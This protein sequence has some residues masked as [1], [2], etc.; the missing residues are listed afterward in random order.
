M[1]FIKTKKRNNALLLTI[2]FPVVKVPELRHVSLYNIDITCNVRAK[3]T[4]T[5][6]IPDQEN[7]T[8]NVNTTGTP[9]HDIGNGTVNVDRSTEDDKDEVEYVMYI[10]LAVGI[11][12]IIVII[13][14]S[15]I[16]LR[17]RYLSSGDSKDSKINLSNSN[18]LTNCSD[19]QKRPLPSKQS[20]T[21]LEALDEPILNQSYS[22]VAD[23]IPRQPVQASLTSPTYA[24]I[25]E[26]SEAGIKPKLPLVNKRS[27]D[28][29]KRKLPAKP[30]EA[31]NSIYSEIEDADE[32]DAGNE[33]EVIYKNKKNQSKIIPVYKKKL[34]N[35]SNIY[36]ECQDVSKT[37][38]E[39]HY[40]DMTHKTA[41]ESEYVPHCKVSKDMVNQSKKDRVSDKLTNQNQPIIYADCD[42]KTNGSGKESRS[43]QLK[44][45]SVTSESDSDDDICMV[46]NELY[47]P[48]ESV[49][50]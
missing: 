41:D 22:V 50:V 25:E 32:K 38:G 20:G 9:D 44:K 29:S 35:A 45:E 40:I 16:Y 18:S 39:K 13:I 14:I 11:L 26:Y 43:K 3:D 36:D 7:D 28:N 1:M 48:F 4:F 34:S 6:H 17:G 42:E 27:V 37:D 15:V 5:Y 23:E 31:Q 19:I 49:K 21:D 46:E 30:D 12:V 10:G 47:E 33:K 2:I 8:S 24:E